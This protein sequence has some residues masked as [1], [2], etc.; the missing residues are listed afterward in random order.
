MAALWLLAFGGLSQPVRAQTQVVSQSGIS[1]NGTVNATPLGDTI[2]M[3]GNANWPASTFLDSFAFRGGIVVGGYLYL[4]PNEA[5]EIVKVEIAT[6]TM[7]GIP[8]PALGGAR[9]KFVGAA[10]DGTYIW[11]IP[12]DADAVVRLDT[13]DDSTTR[14]DAWPAG[15]TKGAGAFSGGIFDGRYVWMVPHNADRVIRLDT[16]DGSMTGF[17]NWPA[18]FT[19]G[20][21]AFWGGVFDGTSMWMF[22]FNA[23]RVVKI[24]TTTGVMTGYNNWPAN[25]TLPTRAFAGGAFDGTRVWMAA[26][27]SDRIISIDVATGAMTGYGTVHDATQWPSGYVKMPG[28][29]NGALYDGDD[30]WF[31]P[32]ESADLIKVDV[33]T[34]QIS[35][36][37][38]YP[39][40]I[41]ATKLDKWAGAAIAGQKLFLIPGVE[42]T[43]VTIEPTPAPAVTAI[44]RFGPPAQ[45]TALDSVVFRV[46]FNK[47]VSGIDASDF[48]LSATGSVS[49]SIAWVSAA[50]G[51]S[52]T[53]TID[54]IAGDGTLRLDLVASGTGIVDDYGYALEGGFTAG[55]SYR[56]DNTAPVITS[57][58]AATVT[59]RGA[60]SYA[61]T[62]DAG[63]AVAFGASGL[64]AGLSLDPGT[65]VI[66]GNP[67]QTGTFNIALSATDAAGNQGSASLTL[68]VDPAPLTVSGL[69]AA[70]KVYDGTTGATLLTGGA[71]LSGVLTGDDVQLALGGAS[72]AFAEPD[73]GN[74]KTVLVSGLSLSGADAAHY[75]LT[76]PALA[77]SITPKPLTVNGMIAADKVYDGTA[78]AS[79]DFAAVVLD[80]VVPGDQV[81]LVTAAATATFADA[82]A[83]SGKTVSVTGLTLSGAQAGNYQ[84]VVPSLSASIAPR[85]VTVSG[86]T[87]SPRLYDGTV[88]APLDF[89]AGTLEGVV[90]GDAVALDT[91]GATA[92]YADPAAGAGKPVSLSGV[93]LSGAD[94]ANYTLL[95]PSLT[96]DIAARPVSV[97]G[98]TVADKVYDGTTAAAI[99]FA[100]ATLSGVVAGDD[101]VLDTAAA[102]AAFGSATAGVDKPVGLAGLALTGADAGNYTLQTPV[103]TATI[104][105]K[106]LTVTGI[107]A[108]DKTYDRSLAA[109][110]DVSAAAI[111]GVV[112]GDSVALDAG[113]AVGVF[114]DARVGEGKPV[115]VSG[116]SLVGAAA[117]N[118]TL[119]PADVHASIQPK[120]VVVGGVVARNKVY[121][122]TTAAVIDATGAW[123]NGVISG[124]DVSLD[125]SA[126][127]GAFADPEVG[128]GKPVTISGLALAGPDA[129]N[130]RLIQPV[131]SAAI[132]PAAATITLAGLERVYDGTPRAVSVE[133]DPAGLSV[134]VTYA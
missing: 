100:A 10:F 45:D 12:R 83:G 7:T 72:A 117:A 81:A 134:Q 85:V 89:T 35:K 61:I 6:G 5:T 124:D 127:T 39:A 130:Y 101:V 109:S 106:P 78:A 118:Y 87:V 133:T 9:D 68:Q 13:A 63:D 79:I 53:V 56:I 38:N 116:L 131:S 67:A 126:V 40:G 51:D 60:F 112:P 31:V 84:I 58:S 105:P 125:T 25:Y 107:T 42:M 43:L 19:K 91:A 37:R 2:I 77:A 57:A 96:G 15:F 21:A 17:S 74:G 123:C 34:G 75:T 94:A 22:P 46:D 82:N 1:F 65:G 86:W 47:P 8:L 55:E 73:A 44:T 110:L 98:I 93:T 121:D 70:D 4:L 104:A 23:D 36:Y 62:T 122:G 16:T 129:G 128:S 59:Y 119:V 114:A 113:G 28:N 27:D 54:N 111:A 120:N 52:V 92:V 132:A 71:A 11:F 14:F 33:A 29:F 102:S 90:P 103:L 26:Y 115:A 30:V 20:P 80:G 50:S 41:D 97:S 32:F 69:A 76:V 49:G 88:S 95:L 108:A 64:P 24:D 66:S 99:D 3:S 18:G 48:T